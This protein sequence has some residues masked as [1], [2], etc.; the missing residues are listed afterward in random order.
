MQK[1]RICRCGIIFRGV[2]PLKALLHSRYRRNISSIYGCMWPQ[3]SMGL[4]TD[5]LLNSTCFCIHTAQSNTTFALTRRHVHIS[6]VH[7]CFWAFPSKII[8]TTPTKPFHFVPHSSRR[9]PETSTTV[10]ILVTT[11]VHKGCVSDCQLDMAVGSV[12][13]LTSTYILAFVVV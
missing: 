11:E 5:T 8:S 10:N 1:I 4:C 9:Q 3:Q 6:F 7:L 12:E 2:S 13:M